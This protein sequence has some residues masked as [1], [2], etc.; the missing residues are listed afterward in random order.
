M[1]GYGKTDI[2]RP[3]TASLSSVTL[4]AEKQENRLSSEP[5]RTDVTGF[6]STSKKEQQADK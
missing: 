6:Q 3:H 5:R 2:D 1:N 4:L